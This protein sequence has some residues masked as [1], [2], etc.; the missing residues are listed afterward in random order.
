MEEEEEEEDGPAAPWVLDEEAAAA[1]DKGLCGPW[2]PGLRLS[3]LS[4]VVAGAAGSTPPVLRC[5]M[6]C[7]LLSSR[8]V[9]ASSTASRRSYHTHA[10]TC[11]L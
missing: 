9:L 11:K 7:S 6:L 5:L 3:S 2:R 10:Y 4:V 1:A 8:A